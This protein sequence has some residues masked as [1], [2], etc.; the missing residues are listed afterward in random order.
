MPMPWTEV[1]PMD[2]K[3]LFLADYLRKSNSFTELCT[4]CGISRKTGYKWV[5]R[6][7]QKGPEGLREQSR[8]PHSNPQ[9][10][11][12]GIRREIVTLREK[13]RIKLGPDKLRSML[14]GRYG[15]EE[16]PSRT[17]IYNILRQEGLIGEK[18]RR[19]RVPSFPQPFA[20]VREPNDLWTADFKGQFL[21]GDGLWCFPLTVMD[22][23]SRYLLGCHCMG[24]IKTHEV[25]AAFE[26]IFRANGLPGR[27]RTDNGVPFASQ[28]LG[29]ISHLSKW[30]IRLGIMP[31]RIQ[32]GKPQQNGVHERMHRTLK[33]AAINPPAST[34]VDQQKQF[35]RFRKEYNEERPHEALGQ[36][37][38][39][40]RY[41]TSDR[42]MPKQLPEIQY[43][44][45]YKISRVSSSGVM[46]CFNRLVYVGHVLTGE[47][48]G[49]EEIKDG[50]WAVFFGPVKLGCF[51]L[52]DKG[53]GNNGY[54][55]LKV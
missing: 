9:Q 24:K 43:P 25:M 33:E 30:W 15:E 27:I 39:A 14:L 51:D 7:L 26:R 29:G 52:H 11:P 46:Y 47:R 32:T 19:R 18:R 34:Q 23:Q 13:G 22:Y 49:M 42:A 12:P 8:K 1:T 4:A 44:G 17:T 35:D 16:V 55:S 28:S 53:R 38:P 48:V 40:M 36:T 54:Y 5:E 45:Y 20:P 3:V 2:Q 50:V 21:T 37:P 10:T 41:R 31:E 6:Y